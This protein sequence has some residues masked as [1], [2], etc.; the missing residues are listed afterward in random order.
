V[1]CPGRYLR[2]VRY[3]CLSTRGVTPG[4]PSYTQVCPLRLL[5]RLVIEPG[6]L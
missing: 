1:V 2:S 3:I 6:Q 4:I 5:K